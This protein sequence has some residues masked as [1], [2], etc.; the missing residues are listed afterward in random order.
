[1]ARSVLFDAMATMLVAMRIALRATPRN[2]LVLHNRRRFA[3][4]E[5]AA[6]EVLLRL[7]ATFRSEAIPVAPVIMLPW[8]TCRHP[9]PAWTPVVPEV[10]KET[11]RRS[12]RLSQRYAA[13]ALRA[14]LEQSER[15]ATAL[16]ERLE[17][18]ESELQR[19]ERRRSRARKEA[20]EVASRIDGVVSRCQQLLQN[21]SNRSRTSIVPESLSTN[22]DTIPGYAA[23]PEQSV[24]AWSLDSVEQQIRRLREEV[25]TPKHTDCTP[26]TPDGQDELTRLREENAALRRKV[27]D[28]SEQTPGLLSPAVSDVTSTPSTTGKSEE[29]HDIDHVRMCAFKEVLAARSRANALAAEVEDLRQYKAMVRDWVCTFVAEKETEKATLVQ[30]LH[31]AQNN[32]RDA[33]ALRMRLATESRARA[34]AEASL[35]ALRAHHA[36][37]ARE[38][39]VRNGELATAKAEMMDARDTY[40]RGTSLA[41]TELAQFQAIAQSQQALAKRNLTLRAQVGALQEKLDNTTAH[42]TTE[43]DRLQESLANM[44]NLANSTQT[45]LAVVERQLADERKRSNGLQATTS[46]TLRRQ[47]GRVLKV[48]G[49]PKKKKTPINQELADKV[50]CL[51]LEVADA[52]HRAR[53]AESQLRDIQNFV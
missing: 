27:L 7:E 24:S 1:M 11:K 38:L 37:L 41:E 9:D 2:A 47:V 32:A 15:E 51:T 43:R 5:G 35:A 28:N 33:D 52:R 48:P 45:R 31:V 46:S 22:P 3:G 49:S 10:K 6:L 17:G 20:A 26:H 19:Y 25:A 12:R 53:T 40:I 29:T 30:S 13:D 36:Q 44:A 23:T 8:V 21:D 18:A 16:R 39:A 42:L 50:N 34:A 4:A 14:L